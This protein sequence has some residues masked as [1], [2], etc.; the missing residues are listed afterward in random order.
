MTRPGRRMAMVALVGLCACAGPRRPVEFGVKEVASDLVL[1]GKP[2]A[3]ALLP[4]PVPPVAFTA[5]LADL[6][7][8]PARA[9]AGTA[10][11]FPPATPAPA[12]ACPAA[13][14][15]APIRVPAP[16]RITAPPQPATYSYRV[17]GAD[18]VGGA[19]PRSVSLPPT[20]T[21]TVR[22]INEASDGS[23]TFVVD[24]TLGGETS[25]TTYHV[26]PAG[27]LVPQA[28]LFLSGMTTTAAGGQ[29]SFTPRPELLLMP[30]PADPGA[31]FT[32]AAT[33]GVTTV[34]LDGTVNQ[35]ARVDACGTPLDAVAIHVEGTVSSAGPRSRQDD[36]K[37]DYFIASGF[38]GLSIQDS[39]ALSSTIL[40]D[41]AATSASRTL[42]ATISRPPLGGGS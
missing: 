21:R 7:P 38:G 16:N 1:G 19:D 27:P 22:A 25:S 41:G 5:S 33:D 20:S 10:P 4:A 24:A 32:A 6:A 36:V 8:Q 14:P 18:T 12:V 30:F 31:T 26:V 15:L 34:K 42:L 39:V 13:D 29:T 28:G 11:A 3:P 35:K 37:A 40:Q 23:F 17:T 9:P 2:P